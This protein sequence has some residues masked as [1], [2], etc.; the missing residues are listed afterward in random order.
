MSAIPPQTPDFEP[1]FVV[2][3]PR[4]GT[5]LLTVL[6]DRHD[7]I[8]M[9]PETHFLI[10]VGEARRARVAATHEALVDFYLNRTHLCDLKLDPEALLARFRRDEPTHRAFLRHA[11]ELFAAQTGKTRVG[12]KS[13]EHLFNVPELLAW[14]PKAK[15]IWL[16]RDGRDCVQAM[17]RSPL[18]HDDRR[19]SAHLWRSTALAGLALE[20]RYPGRIL[21]VDFQDLIND[22]RRELT[23]VCDFIGVE[24]QERQLDAKTESRVVLPQ[25]LPLKARANEPI[26]PRRVGRYVDETTDREKWLMDSVMAAP[27]ARLG[28]APTDVRRPPVP[29]RLYDGLMNLPHLALYDPRLRPLKSWL[30]RWYHRLAPRRPRQPAARE[31]PAPASALR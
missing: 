4:S 8:A 29:V 23:R 11:L 25:E 13:P 15:V 30:S 22:P 24:F 10:H 20:S 16:L 21:R 6:L 31:G 2:A 1:I 27:L 9:T 14:Y 28:Y 18:F 19:R 5:T 7:Q 26:D 12:E 3:C 17:M